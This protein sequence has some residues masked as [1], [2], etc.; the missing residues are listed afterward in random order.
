MECN[1]H[2][3]PYKRNLTAVPGTG[4]TNLAMIPLFQTMYLR[5]YV[6]GYIWV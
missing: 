5:I 2:R 3:K 4:K 6:K 1:V